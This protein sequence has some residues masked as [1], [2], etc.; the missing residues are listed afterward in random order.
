MAE[1]IKLIANPIFQPVWFMI[2]FKGYL[3]MR[4]IK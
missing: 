2:L 4:G 3:L 1:I